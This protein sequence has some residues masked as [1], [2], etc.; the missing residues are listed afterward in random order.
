[1]QS[2]TM[3]AAVFRLLLPRR[4]RQRPQKASWP[5]RTRF[6]PLMTAVPGLR[7]RKRRR[8]PQGKLPR[9]AARG[10]ESVDCGH[11]VVRPDYTEAVGQRNNGWR[12]RR[13][14]RVARTVTA[15][16]D[17]SLRCNTQ[18]QPFA[19]VFPSTSSRSVPRLRV[20]FLPDRLVRDAC[21]G[22]TVNF[23]YNKIA[24]SQM[25]RCTHSSV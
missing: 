4:F 18:T 15:A 9:S 6:E 12:C 7:A 13:K 16:H 14:R 24:L 19:Q 1:M 11:C 8:R 21:A 2:V 23:R 25:F 22:C 17:A 5:S 20:S 10:F 3:A